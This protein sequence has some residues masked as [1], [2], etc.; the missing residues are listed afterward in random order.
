MVIIKYKKLFDICQLNNEM[1]EVKIVCICND[2][3]FI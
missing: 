3:F 1:Q 2:R